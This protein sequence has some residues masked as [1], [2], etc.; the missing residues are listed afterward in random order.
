MAV[1]EVLLGDGYCH[2]ITNTAECDYDGGDCCDYEW[3]IKRDYCSECTCHINE[4]CTSEGGHPLAGDG[5][6][7]DETN[8]ETCMFD[9]MDCSRGDN[10]DLLNH[11]RDYEDARTTYCTECLYQGMHYFLAASTNNQLSRV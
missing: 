6:C 11:I 9:G 1:S 10:E 7:N 5:F 4:T 3:K 2:D 8:I